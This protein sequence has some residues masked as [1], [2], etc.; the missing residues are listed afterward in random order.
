M[1]I[2]APLPMCPRSLYDYE[3]EDLRPHS[4]LWL[5]GQWGFLQ[6]SRIVVYCPTI[7]LSSLMQE[8]TL[9]PLPLLLFGVNHCF[10][11]ESFFIEYFSESCQL[12]VCIKHIPREK[13]L[14][15]KKWVLSYQYHTQKTV[16]ARQ[17]TQSGFPSLRAVVSG[18]C[19]DRPLLHI[20]I[21]LILHEILRV[22]G[23]S[24]V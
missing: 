11:E 21:C 24:L 4:E 15:D 6:E 1:I 14:S 18:E 22:W 8:E 9:T 12:C 20:F 19:V 7:L 10:D 13:K 3:D 5:L 16:R 2:L 23:L 17:R